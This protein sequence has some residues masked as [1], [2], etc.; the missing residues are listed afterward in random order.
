MSKKFKPGFQIFALLLLFMVVFLGVFYYQSLQVPDTTPPA[1]QT[2]PGLIPALF[3][4]QKTITTE[5]QKAD[6][7]FKSATE[8]F[9]Y[10]EIPLYK[11]TKEDGV[12]SKIVADGNLARNMI[13]KLPEPAESVDPVLAKV[14]S[15]RNQFDRLIPG[16]PGLKLNREATLKAFEESIQT[17]PGTEEIEISLVMQEFENEGGLKEKMTRLG[18]TKA[19]ASFTAIHNDYIDNDE[20]NENLR[21][22]AEKIDGIIMPPGGKFNFD[23]VVGKR[24]EKN[25]FKKAGVI[26]QGRTIQGLG[27]GIC[28]VSTA[29][30]NAVLL[31]G[32]KIDERHNHS[33]YDGIEYAPHGLDSAIAWGYKNLRFTNNLDFPVLII[34]KAGKGIAEVEVYAENEPFDSVI[35][36]TRKLSK[37]PFKTETRRNTK[38]SPGEIKVVHPGVTGFSVESYRIFTQNGSNREERLSRDRYLTY[39]RIEEINN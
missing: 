17:N 1:E 37:H 4:P 11:V 29:L 39:N 28:Q 32:L 7:I 19:I 36:E 21:L 14:V 5:T 6:I 8:N 27:G 9:E 2:K 10:R 13:K 16:H 26:S 34:C 22:A 24:S 33:I 18:F 3:A 15:K 31:A 12:T 38:L 30:Y 35:L 23:R 20:R 25:G